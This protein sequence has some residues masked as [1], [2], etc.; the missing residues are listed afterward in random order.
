[1][2]ALGGTNDAASGPRRSPIG[3]ISGGTAENLRSTALKRELY[4]TNSCQSWSI[5]GDL[6]GTFFR[7]RFWIFEDPFFEFLRVRV[8]VFKIIFE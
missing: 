6:R 4:G 1:M 2:Q 3:A 5:L 7:V 8:F